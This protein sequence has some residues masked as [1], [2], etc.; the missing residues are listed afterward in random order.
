MM[1]LL[2][3]LCLPT[4]SDGRTMSWEACGKN[5]SWPSWSNYFWIRTKGLSKTKNPCNQD[6]RCRP[7]SDRATYR[8]TNWK[9]HYRRHLARSH[10]RMAKNRLPTSHGVIYYCTWNLQVI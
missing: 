6:N 4:A 5:R 9:L 1:I 3:L 8:N 10:A 7:L 2:L